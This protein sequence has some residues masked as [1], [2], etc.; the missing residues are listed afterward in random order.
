MNKN[1]PTVTDGDWKQNYSEMVTT[2]NSAVK[3]VRSGQR[4]FIGT[5]AACPQ[6]LVKALTSRAKQLADVE[7]VHLLTLGDAPYAQ[8]KYRDNFRVNSFFIADNVRE[9]IQGGYGDYTPIFLS[10]VPRLFNSGQM[11]LDVALIQVSPPDDNGMCSLGVSVDVVRSAARNASLVIAEVNPQMPRVFGDASIDIYDIDLLVPIDTPLLEIQPPPKDEIT[12]RIGEHVASLVESGATLELGIGSIPQAILQFMKEKSDLGIHTEMLTDEIIDLVESGTVNGSLKTIDRGKVVAS[13]CMG[14]RRL[15][16]YVDNNPTFEFHPTEYV[17]DSYIIGQHNKMIA[18]NVGMEVDLTGQVCADS[19]G[20]KFYS[21]IGGQ[22]DFNRGAA[23]S[24]GGRAV[25]ALPSTA[26][27]GTISRIVSNLEPGAGVVTSRGGV[28]YVVTEHGVAYL[29]GKSVQERAL[30]LISIAHPDFREKLLHEAIE[31]K[32]VRQELQD[33]EGKIVV[34]PKEFRATHILADGTEVTARPVHPTDQPLM[35]DLFYKLSE[36][37]VYYRFFTHLKRFPQREIQQFVYIDHRQ[38]EAVVVTVPGAN[39]EEIIG[40][41]RYYLDTKTNRAEVAFVV[42]DE[43]Q[44]QGIGKFLLET[45]SQIAKRNGIHGFTAEVLADNKAMQAV[46]NHSRL[47][48]NSELQ[49][50]VYSYTL[51]FE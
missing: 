30:A 32:Y 41:G 1:S 13:F 39:R 27:K 11:L 10:D 23:R 19:L 50:R 42:A 49:E 48:V 14:T 15:F 12:T 43:W 2:A 31:K 7:I 6:S 18:I 3:K 29:H 22:I 16:D 25:I 21:G 47:K 8:K 36:E 5:G 20:T 46:F 4:I 45:L 35:K 34:G 17:N 33:V 40:V 26:K 9:A 51:D 28:H 44:G 24:Q 37:A 38:D